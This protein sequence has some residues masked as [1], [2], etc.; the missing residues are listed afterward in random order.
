MEVAWMNHLMIISQVL[1]LPWLVFA[2]YS[3]PVKVLN[4]LLALPN[5][6]DECVC[7]ETQSQ[8]R[9]PL[10]GRAAQMDCAWNFIEVEGSELVW[11]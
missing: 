7:I 4:S 11:I 1:P 8:R 2:V 9:H 6:F 5:S 3:V 10:V